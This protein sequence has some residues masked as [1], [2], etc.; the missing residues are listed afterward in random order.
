M[1]NS[2]ILAITACIALSLVGGVAVGGSE[3]SP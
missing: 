2:R 1:H 3:H